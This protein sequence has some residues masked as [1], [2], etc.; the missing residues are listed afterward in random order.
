MFGPSVSTIHASFLASGSEASPG[1]ANTSL[2]HECD[3][4]T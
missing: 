3:A 1:P 4:P 2:L